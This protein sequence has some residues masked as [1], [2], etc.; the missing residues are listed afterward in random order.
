MWVSPCLQN[1]PNE[2]CKF[3]LL[4][5]RLSI[6]TLLLEG[7][8]FLCFQR[9][10]FQASRVGA[11]ATAVCRSPTPA[12]IP[13]GKRAGRNAQDGGA[14]E[15]APVLIFQPCAGGGGRRRGLRGVQ[16]VLWDG[17]TGPFTA[18]DPRRNLAGRRPAPE[19][20]LFV[21]QTLAELLRLF[22]P[23]PHAASDQ[24]PFI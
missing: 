2:R 4:R 24:T 5:G 23:P 14:K 16:Q 17:L 7:S 1:R 8:H 10:V 13:G 12:V 6:H 18:P 15:E 9:D 22:L 11:S 21:A 3:P 19:G 20:I